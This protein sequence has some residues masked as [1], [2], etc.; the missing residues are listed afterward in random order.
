MGSECPEWTVASSDPLFIGM[1]NNGQWSVTWGV[2]GTDS[3]VE[4]IMVT[5]VCFTMKGRRKN[6]FYVIYFVWA[7]SFL[8]CQRGRMHLHCHYMN[9]FPFAH[10]MPVT[11]HLLLLCPK[12][13]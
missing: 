6:P 4:V 3:A 5:T 9:F 2:V 11:S 10:N 8:P 12:S 7:N 13:I 1:Q